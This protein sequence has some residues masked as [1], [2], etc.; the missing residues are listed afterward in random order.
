MN[1]QIRPLSEGDTEGVIQISLQAWTPVFTPW[2]F[3]VGDWTFGGLI[4]FT[5]LAMGSLFAVG[6]GDPAIIVATTAFALA[7]P[8]DVTGLVLLRPVQDLQRVGIE[9]E[10]ARAFQEAGVAVD[11]QVPAFKDLEALRKRRTRRVLGYCLGLVVLSA[12]LTVAG[13]VAVLWHTA[14][15]IAVAFVAMVVISQVLVATVIVTSPPPV[16]AGTARRD[17]G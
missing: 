8:L 15:W 11:E 14:W 13:M 9:E 1:L 12:V 4:A 7:L 5:L 3:E 6:P 16:P 10:V 17:G 2:L